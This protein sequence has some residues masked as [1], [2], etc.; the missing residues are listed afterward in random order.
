MTLLAE[1]HVVPINTNTLLLLIEVAVACIISA[2]YIKSRIPQE[3][4]KEQTSLIATLKD[5]LDEM[6]KTNKS[7]LDQQNT[8]RA[9]INKL[10]GQIEILRD[11]PLKSIAAALNLTTPAAVTVNTVP[12]TTVVTDRRKV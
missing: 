12:D 3:T 9:L 2:L 4:I 10:E 11:L 8:D 5:R 6:D 1:V 7:L